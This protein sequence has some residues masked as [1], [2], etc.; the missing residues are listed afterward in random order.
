MKVI[1]DG[2]VR[3]WR[4]CKCKVNNKL[5]VNAQRDGRPVEYRWRPLFNVAKFAWRWL[6]EC[7]AVK[8]P[9]RETRW[10][11]LVCPKLANRSQPLVGRSSPYC[12]DMWGRRC[13]LT[14]FPIVDMCVSCEDIA[15]Q[16][17][18]M[19]PRRR[20]FDDFLRPAFPASRMQHISDLHSKSAVGHAM[21]RSMV[22]IQSA[23]A[24]IRRREREEE[25]KEERR[26]KKKKEEER[27]RKKEEEEIGHTYNGL[28]YSI[29]RP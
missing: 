11:L 14:F 18:S 22:D 28:S 8:L 9:R 3:P 1:E 4:T 16:S 24:E 19:V 26:R 5:W 23:T 17:C 2:F 20:I 7:R 6:L 21:C 27:R 15:R 29:G 10:N 25:K 12:E 13:C